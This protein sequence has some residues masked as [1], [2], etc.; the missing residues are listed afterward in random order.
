[1]AV[2]EWGRLSLLENW[3]FYFAT[4]TTVCEH[5]RFMCEI[6]MQVLA[7]AV[8]NLG[9]VWVGD[10]SVGVSVLGCW[11]PVCVHTKQASVL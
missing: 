4:E 2:G 11:C 3:C 8:W 10:N 7:G 6:A 5:T 1:M 9:N